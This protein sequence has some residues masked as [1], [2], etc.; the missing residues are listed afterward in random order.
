MRV[1]V[2]KVSGVWHTNPTPSTREYTFNANDDVLHIGRDALEK[3]F[4]FRVNILM[5]HRFSFLIQNTD[6]HFSGVQIDAAV[7]LVLPVVE[8]HIASFLC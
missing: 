1:R 3:R 7:I 5:N 6:V 2:Q 8:V 4:G